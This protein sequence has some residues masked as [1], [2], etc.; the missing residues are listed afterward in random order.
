MNLD[1]SILKTAQVPVTHFAS[2][3]GASRVAAS[4]WVNGKFNPRGLY[5]EKADAVLQK[6]QAA[7]DSGH[8]PLARNT[9]R[10]KRLDALLTV[11]S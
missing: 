5:H 8:L 7:L 6:I 3:C 10:D 1:F 11:L 2:L 9:R 4:L